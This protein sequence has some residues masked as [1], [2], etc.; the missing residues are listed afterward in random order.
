MAEM[1]GGFNRSVSGPEGLVTVLS[2]VQAEI[3]YFSF[4]SFSEFNLALILAN[5]KRRLT[6]TSGHSQKQKTPLMQGSCTSWIG[7]S[8]RENS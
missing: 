5:A 2:A 8:A 6:A 1:G 7:P 4:G 3:L